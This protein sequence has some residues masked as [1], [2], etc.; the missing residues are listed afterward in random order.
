M[1][2]YLLALG[3]FVAVWYVMQAVLLPKMGVPT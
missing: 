3:V 2:T 1:A